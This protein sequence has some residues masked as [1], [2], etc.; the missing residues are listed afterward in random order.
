M[1]LEPE[2]KEAGVEQHQ[3][4]TPVKPTTYA[5][6]KHKTEEPGYRVYIGP[7]IRGHVQYGAVFVSLAE[8]RAELEREFARFPAFGIFLVTGQQL[9]EARIDVKTPGTA[10]YEQAKKLRAEL[11]KS[12]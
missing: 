6:R 7:S 1:D 11:T 9:P 10:L 2:T 12:K 8:A 4:M 5:R 3:D